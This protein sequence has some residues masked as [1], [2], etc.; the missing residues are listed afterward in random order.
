MLEE[1]KENFKNPKKQYLKKE[2]I[3]FMSG[4]EDA[5]ALAQDDD[6][7]DAYTAKYNKLDSTENNQKGSKLANRCRKFFQENASEAKIQFKKFREY[8][9]E[10]A[11]SESNEPH[12]LRSLSNFLK[13]R[14]EEFVNDFI[15]RNYALNQEFFDSYRKA[16]EKRSEIE[17]KTNKS[18]KETIPEGEILVMQKTPLAEPLSTNLGK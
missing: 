8:F 3:E 1:I 15:K 14:D 13:S 6:F 11:I 9:A 4:I 12:I 16:A 10:I 18:K 7:L 17:I 2:F 5:I